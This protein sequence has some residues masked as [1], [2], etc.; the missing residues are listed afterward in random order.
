MN[1][2][3]WLQKVIL[4]RAA[5][6]IELLLEAKGQSRYNGGGMNNI[7]PQYIKVLHVHRPYKSFTVSRRL[8]SAMFKWGLHAM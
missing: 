5:E 7:C 2:Y 3:T 4:P 8:S 6:Q 1:V